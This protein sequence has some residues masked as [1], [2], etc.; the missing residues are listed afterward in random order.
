MAAAHRRR[1]TAIQRHL[2]ATTT[3]VAAPTLI[4]DADTGIQYAELELPGKGAT[5]ERLEH[6]E[7]FGFVILDDFVD[8]PLI[9][10]MREHAARIAR[11]CNADFPQ[12]VHTAGYIHRG[13]ENDTTSAIRGL[14]HPAFRSPCFAEFMSCPEMLDFVKSFT[15]LEKE[16]LEFGSA[17]LIFC[18]GNSE[19][20]QQ[21]LQEQWTPGGGGWHRDGRWW[22]GDDSQMMFNHQKD[23]A[24][25]DYSLQAEEIRW[26]EWTATPGTRFV[27]PPSDDRPGWLLSSGFFLA[28]MDDECH[29]VDPLTP[30][31]LLLG[32]CCCCRCCCDTLIPP[33]SVACLAPG[34]PGRSSRSPTSAFAQPSNTTCFYP[35]PRRTRVFRTL[36]TGMA[37]RSCQMSRRFGCAQAS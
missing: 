19:P 2:A 36:L 34:L 26:S 24:P 23:E 20:A 33:R 14:Y 3:G 16:Q 22:G 37:S 35:S 11:E 13:V 18:S 4:L 6:L 31:Y 15:G 1:L 10:V 17:P 9:P 25:Y 21:K 32:C 7:K 27:E 30:T 8:H 28:L 29:E 5:P 12:A